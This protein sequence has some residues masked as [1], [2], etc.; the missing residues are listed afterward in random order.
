MLAFLLLWVN[1]EIEGET[2][3]LFHDHRSIINDFN[4]NQNFEGAVARAKCNSAALCE[5]LATDVWFAIVTAVSQ[6]AT[7]H[8]KTLFHCAHVNV[9][10]STSLMVRVLSVRVCT[11]AVYI[12]GVHAACSACRSDR[13]A[14]DT[15]VKSCMPRIA[16]TRS[17]N[18][19]LVKAKAI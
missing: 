19:S 11:C 12:A 17:R 7:I 6:L 15:H 1:C 8:A 18:P 2:H 3:R 9:R 14:Y 16:G 4:Y 5:L 13:D 10:T